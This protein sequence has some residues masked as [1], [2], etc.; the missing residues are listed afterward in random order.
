MGFDADLADFEFV[1]AGKFMKTKEFI[2]YLKKY[3]GEKELRFDFADLGLRGDTTKFSAREWSN[4]VDI[5]PILPKREVV[6]E[7]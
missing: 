4:C 2:E 1:E 3:D 7:N 5:L 6:D